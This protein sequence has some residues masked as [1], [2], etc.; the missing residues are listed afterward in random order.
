MTK[1]INIVSRTLKDIGALEAGKIIHYFS[2]GV[3][4]KETYIPMST[5]K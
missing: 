3:Y 5:S 4:A 2:L 1:P